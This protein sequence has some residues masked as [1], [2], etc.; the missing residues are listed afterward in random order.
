MVL[1]RSVLLG[2][3]LATLDSS[4]VSTALVTIGDDFGN[5]IQTIWIVLAYLISYMS[6][7][8]SQAVTLRRTRRRTLCGISI[9]LS[10]LFYSLLP[11]VATR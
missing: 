4:I 5:F 2:L 11:L 10:S 7:Y 8:F 6:M 9:G 1:T 3:F